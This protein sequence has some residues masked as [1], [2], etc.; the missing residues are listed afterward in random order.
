M[1]SASG[2]GLADHVCWNYGEEGYLDAAVA[3]LDD[4]R[5]AGQRLLY[6]ADRPR[7]A[8]IDD[9]A[10]LDARD[11]LRASGGLIVRPLAEAHGGD[12]IRPRLLLSAYDAATRQA[13]ADGFTGLRAVGES[14]PLVRD[15][16]DR[17]AW[18]R[19]EHVADRWIAMGN[20][21]AALCAFDRRV[22]GSGAVDEILQLHPLVHRC[23]GDV[24][25]RL[26]GDGEDIALDGQVDLFSARDLRRALAH[27][28]D[29]E[30]LVLDLSEV[31]F[32]DHHGL[33]TLGRHG[34]AL[35]RAGAA[36]TL[37]GASPTV[38]LAW[39]MLRLDDAYPVTF[40]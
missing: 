8:L 7:D 25:F 21:F 31:E 23:D 39:G 34:E 33:L 11:A 2:L 14:T 13:L 40:R 30:S 1:A 20:P 5:R 9:L 6:V 12:R 37:R 18:A 4:G 29:G 10:G 24:A 28:G 32:I 35:A 17:A 38:R 19:W 27:A 36:L 3:F 16:A 26:F 15:P 22:L